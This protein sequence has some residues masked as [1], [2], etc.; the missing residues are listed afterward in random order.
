[1]NGNLTEKRFMVVVSL[2]FFDAHCRD[3]SCGICC[4]KRRVPFEVE[5]QFFSRNLRTPLEFKGT[6]M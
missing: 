4:Q 2:F 5:G 1:M 6:E 3:W